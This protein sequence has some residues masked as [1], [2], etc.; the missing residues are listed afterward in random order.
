MRYL[1]GTFE[2]TTWPQISVVVFMA[3]FIG[4]ILWVYRPKG[5]K[6]YEEEARMPLEDEPNN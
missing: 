3:A 4:L 2:L 5:K 6:R 1:L